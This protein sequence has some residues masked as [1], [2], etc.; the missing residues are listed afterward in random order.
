MSSS[1]TRPWP[2]F[3]YSTQSKYKKDGQIQKIDVSG[4][5]GR[6]LL[7][8]GHKAKE[9]KMPEGKGNDTTENAFGM[10]LHQRRDAG[11]GRAALCKTWIEG[12]YK[13]WI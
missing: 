12:A 7:V 3:S 4:K 11:K 1:L 10:F 2:S 8:T 13:G 6:Q 5:K 9:A